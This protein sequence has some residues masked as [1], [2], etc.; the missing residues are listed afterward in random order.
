MANRKK[1][2]TA[3]RARSKTKARARKPTATPT[4]DEP[5]VT[6]QL[7]PSRAPLPDHDVAPPVTTTSNKHHPGDVDAQRI[8]ERKPSSDEA[9]L[10]YDVVR[11][12][13]SMDFKSWFD[14]QLV[15]HTLDSVRGCVRQDLLD[16]VSVGIEDWVDRFLGVSPTVFHN[17]TKKIGDEQWFS[18]VTIQQQ[19]YAFCYAYEE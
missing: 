13:I 1:P 6:L 18:D 8:H 3:K 9:C 7:M 4:T 11:S 15:D 12:P 2:T 10:A 14:A 5:I 17:L 19:M 16:A